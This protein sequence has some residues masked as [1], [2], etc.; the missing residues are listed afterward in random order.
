M[1]AGKGMS[2]LLMQSFAALYFLFRKSEI[3]ILVDFLL[4]HKGF[5]FDK[6][7]FLS[8]RDFCVSSPVPSLLLT[9]FVCF[10]CLQTKVKLVTQHHSTIPSTSRR[11]V[12]CFKNMATICVATKLC[13]TV[14]LDENWLHRYRNIENSFCF[15]T[16]F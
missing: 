9:W 2:I 6:L 10:S 1:F 7:V 3:P 12:I 8:V 15:A 4:I 14:I 16:V 13:I 5:G 11:S